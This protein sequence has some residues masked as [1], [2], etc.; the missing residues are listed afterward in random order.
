MGRSKDKM[1]KFISFII[2]IIMLISVLV[3]PEPIEVHAEEEG[4]NTY[5]IN[6]KCPDSV[7]TSGQC[8]VYEVQGQ[9]TLPKRYLIASHVYSSEYVNYFVYD[10]VNKEVYTIS[11]FLANVLHYIPEATFEGYSRYYISHID[12]G[13]VYE[14]KFYKEELEVDVTYDIDKGFYGRSDWMTYSVSIPLF[15]SEAQVYQYFNGEIDITEAENYQ[16]DILK[17]TYNSSEVPL[18]RNLRVEHED[19]NYYIAW[20]YTSEDLKKL[21]YV[22]FSGMEMDVEARAKKIGKYLPFLVDFEVGIDE[23]F[24]PRLTYKL[25][26]T[27]DV[28]RLRKA[29]ED[30]IGTFCDY[31]ATLNYVVASAWKKSDFE[32][33]H[34]NI[35]HVNLYLS[36]TDEG[37]IVDFDTVVTDNELNVLDDVKFDTS[38]S[39]GNAISSNDFIGNIASGFKLLGDNGLIALLTA[40]LV[41]IP[42][43]LWMIIGTALSIMVIVALFKLVI[44]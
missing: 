34:S 42:S 27:D 5:N 17:T 9:L 15:E 7:Y 11:R 26:V 29:I 2:C 10:T 3:L 24:E 22:G 30:K 32:I 41:F 8:T 40:S 33:Y 13:E 38:H 1:K 37:F 28:S 25:D 39:S 16:T 35:A 18:P 21:S 31:K 20:E 43:P 12:I 19:Y 6:I 44:K 23:I 4:Y 14:E 36:D